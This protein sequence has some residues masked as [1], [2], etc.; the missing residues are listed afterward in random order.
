MYVRAC[1]CPAAVACS[2]AFTAGLQMLL[3]VAAAQ[4]V[5][6]VVALGR[7]QL[8]I[9]QL[10]L[11]DRVRAGTRPL[12]AAAEEPRL[13]YAPQGHV[14]GLRSAWVGHGVEVEGLAGVSSCGSARAS[15]LLKSYTLRCLRNRKD[16]G[17]N[18]SNHKGELS[19]TINEPQ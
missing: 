6:Q 2:E 4:G 14:K 5:E 8:L 9:P 17:T 7:G 3:S 1:A 13:A 18:T 15:R 10:A 19:S 11:H 12:A 16:C